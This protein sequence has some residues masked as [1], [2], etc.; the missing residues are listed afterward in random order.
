MRENQNMP[1]LKLGYRQSSYQVSN[2]FE[3][4]HC[5]F[6]IDCQRTTIFPIQPT[7]AKVKVTTSLSSRMIH[8]KMLKSIRQRHVSAA[9]YG[10]EAGL[11]HAYAQLSIKPG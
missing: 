8:L 1:K 6:K 5:T 7:Q 3:L 10:N 9:V 4:Y 2:H 11:H